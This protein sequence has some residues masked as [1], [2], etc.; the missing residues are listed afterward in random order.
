M[1]FSWI[2]GGVLW[3]LASAGAQEPTYR[4]AERLSVPE[5]QERSAKEIEGMKDTL[6]QSLE[7][8][9]SARERKDILQVN[10]VNDKLAAIKGL[11][12]I[13]ESAWT[14]LLEAVAKGDE[15]LINHE[16]TKISIAGVRVENFRVEVEGCV[17]EASQYIGETVVEASIDPDIRADDPTQVV[18]PPLP[19]L[20]V[21]QRPP[22]N[23]VSE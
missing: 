1:R 9:K 6:R 13:S 5:K 14:N 20:E 17:G 8:L 4:N 18:E 2:M 7:R 16:F 12:K 3:A 19:P 10:C 23:S 21:D 22:P 11:L 15:D